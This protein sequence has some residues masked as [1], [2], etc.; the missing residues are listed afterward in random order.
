MS[1]AE[2]DATPASLTT[3]WRDGR[4]YDG[5]GVDVTEPTRLAQENG[6]TLRHALKA[7]G[8]AVSGTKRQQAK[9]LADAGVTSEHVK[10]RHNWRIR[11]H[12]GDVVCPPGHAD[13]GDPR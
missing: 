1:R 3:M 5:N 13:G 2:S 7:H 6:D 12:G 10:E 11:Q 8:L 4:A 9:R